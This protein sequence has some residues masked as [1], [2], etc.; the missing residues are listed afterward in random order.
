MSFCW[1][2]MGNQFPIRNP[3]LNCP[4]IRQSAKNIRERMVR[5]ELALIGTPIDSMKAPGIPNY[6]D[7]QFS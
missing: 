1:I 3:R 4:P 5:I 7:H 6:P 2:G